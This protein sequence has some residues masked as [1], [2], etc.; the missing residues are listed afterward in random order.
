M[1]L[2]FLVEGRRT[3]KKVYRAWIHHVF[4]DLRE[5]ATIEEVESN[6]FFLIHGGGYPLYCSRIPAALE[7][8]VRHG[9][10]DGFSICI[11]AEGYSVESKMNEINKITSEA[12]PFPNCH[13]IVHNC[14]METWF[15]GYRKMLRRNPQREQLRAFKQFYDVSRED[16]EQMG[17]P[18]EYEFRAQFHV[19]YL[20]EMLRER[21]LSYTKSR[22]GCVTEKHYFNA[23][24]E[25]NA[26]TGHLNSFRRLIKLWEVFGGVI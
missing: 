2:Y 12:S 15:L 5:A 22:P 9:V 16:P 3:E 7:D 24:V 23:L 6:H 21:G 1:N 8:I 10:I 25:R 17:C 20:K 26:Q 11:D 4:P 18:P 14:C 13:V 19:T